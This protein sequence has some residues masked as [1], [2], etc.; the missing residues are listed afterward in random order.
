MDGADGSDSA[1]MAKEADVT[2]C[3]TRESTVK[4]HRDCDN[5]VDDSVNDSGCDVVDECCP[6]AASE[7]DSNGRTIAGEAKTREAITYSGANRNQ[8]GANVNLTNRQKCDIFNLS[9]VDIGDEDEDDDPYAE[10]EFYLEKVK[11]S[12]VL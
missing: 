5:D 4:R 11:V 12:T 8:C 6:L 1:E 10:L 3:Q 9:N 2:L 7:M